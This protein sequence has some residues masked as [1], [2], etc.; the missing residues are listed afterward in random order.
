MEYEARE[1]IIRSLKLRVTI[2]FVFFFIAIFTVFIITS[3]LQVNTVVRFVCSLIG[4]PAVQRVE[5]LIDGDRF[6]AFCKSPDVLDP[7]YEETRLQM[8]AIRRTI[9]CRYLYTMAPVTNEVWEYI[10]DGSTSPD[11]KEQFSPLGTE[12]DISAYDAAFFDTLREKRS[13]LGT[14]D[15]NETWGPL[16]SAYAPILNSAG[17]VVGIIGCDLE[18]VAIIAWIRAQVT[19]QLGAVGLLILA[20]LAVYISLTRRL[21]LLSQ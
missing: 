18:A 17:E 2:F 21:S 8:L 11:D 20:G 9:N 3:V 5:A 6:E 16:I 10:I 13:Q 1:R 4:M 19:W 14:I 12:E 15:Q 7:Y